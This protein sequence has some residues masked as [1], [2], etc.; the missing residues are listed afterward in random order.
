VNH[1][2]AGRIPTTRWGNR[3]RRERDDPRRALTRWV[4]GL[5]ALALLANGCGEGSRKRQ[6]TQLAPTSTTQAARRST[7]I[8]FK[9]ADG[10]PLEGA[11][12]PGRGRRAPAVI[13]I[14]QYR[15]GPEQWEGFVPA[16]QRA[17]YAVLN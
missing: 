8:R 10:V 5:V 2:L 15:G 6:D 1:D 11:L 17:G 9:A 4:R 16:L 7:T 13:L 14:H 3:P 12:F